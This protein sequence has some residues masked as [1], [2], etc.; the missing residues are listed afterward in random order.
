MAKYR[1]TKKYAEGSNVTRGRL[2]QL[3]RQETGPEKNFGNLVGDI[4]KFA[5]N[6]ALTPIETITGRN[7]YDPEFTYSTMNKVDAVSSGVSSAATDIAGTYFLGPFYTGGK[8]AIQAGVNKIDADGSWDNTNAQVAMFGGPIHYGHGSRVNNQ[9]IPRYFDASMVTSMMGSGGGGGFDMGSLMGMFGGQGGG[10]NMW[11]DLSSIGNNA[12]GGGNMNL[13][14]IMNTS[15]GGQNPGGGSSFLSAINPNLTGT[16]MTSSVDGIT[17]NEKG[18]I[19]LGATWNTRKMDLGVGQGEGFGADFKTTMSGMGNNMATNAGSMNLNQW[20][21]MLT[22]GDP[23]TIVNA[24]NDAGRNT[25]NWSGV[26]NFVNNLTSDTV[27][28]TKAKEI[29]AEAIANQQAI[30]TDQSNMNRYSSEGAADFG[31]VDQGNPMQDAYTKNAQGTSNVKSGWA[32]KTGQA[33]AQVGD[34]ASS[35]VSGDMSSMGGGMDMTSMM[36]MMGTARDGGNTQHPQDDPTFKMWYAKNARRPDVM[37][38]GNTDELKAIFLKEIGMPGNEMP[39]FSG[40]IDGYGNIDKSNRTPE[41]NS[42]IIGGMNKYGSKAKYNM[43][44]NV[45]QGAIPPGLKM[46]NG[47]LNVPENYQGYFNIPG[48]NHEDGGTLMNTPAEGQGNTLIEA[49]LNEGAEVKN[50]ETYIYSKTT[51][52][53][54]TGETFKK[55]KDKRE[56]ESLQID[57]LL[58][59]SEIQK[60][61]Y[62]LNALTRRK[63]TL[64]LEE[65]SDRALQ[66][67]IK[68]KNE[69]KDTLELEGLLAANTNISKKGTYRRGGRTR[70]L[71]E[72]QK[73]ML[74]DMLEK[75]MIETYQD[76]SN[77][78]KPSM[79]DY[80]WNNGRGGWKAGGEEKYN[81][82]LEAWKN[83]DKTTTEENDD[84]TRLPNEKEFDEINRRQKLGERTEDIVNDINNRNL[85]VSPDV[86]NPINIPVTNPQNQP[87]VNTDDDLPFSTEVDANGNTRYM[88]NGI[89]RSAEEYD[90]L[91]KQ[92]NDDPDNFATVPFAPGNIDVKTNTEVPIETNPLIPIDP[93]GRNINLNPNLPPNPETTPPPNNQTPNIPENNPLDITPGNPDDMVDDLLE[94]IDSKKVDNVPVVDPRDPSTDPLTK[95]ILDQSD[96]NPPVESTVPN[97]PRDPST[98]PLTKE[99]LDQSDVNQ[100]VESTVPNNPNPNAGEVAGPDE[101]LWSMLE[102][103]RDNPGGTITDNRT[104]ANTEGGGG[105]G[106]GDGGDGTTTPGGGTTTNEN[107]VETNQ[108]FPADHCPTGECPD[109]QG[110]CLPC[111]NENVVTANTTPPNNPPNTNPNTNPNITNNTTSNTSSYKFMQHNINPYDWLGM[112]GL[113]HGALSGAANTRENWENTPPNVNFMKDVYKKPIHRLNMNTEI[114]DAANMNTDRQLREDLNTQLQRIRTSGNSFQNV[115]ARSQNAYNTYASN[116]IDADV[117]Y[118]LMNLGLQKDIADLEGK[119]RKL[120]LEGEGERDLADR[121]D[122]DNYYTQRGKDIQNTA[123]NMM[124]MAKN[125]NAS[126]MEWL[127]ANAMNDL[128]GGNEPLDL[129]NTENTTNIT[130]ITNH[131]DGTTCPGG[132][133]THPDHITEDGDPNDNTDGNDNT[134][135]NTTPGANTNTFYNVSSGNNFETNFSGNYAPGTAGHFQEFARGMNLDLGDFGASGTEWE[136][137]DNNI[138]KYT[139]AAWD[140]SSNAYRD[141]LERSGQLGS[142]TGITEPSELGGTNLPFRRRLSPD[143]GQYSTYTNFG[144]FDNA[145]DYYNSLSAENQQILKENDPD[146]FGSFRRGSRVKYGYGSRARRRPRKYQDAHNVLSDKVVDNY[147]GLGITPDMLNQMNVTPSD[148]LLTSNLYPDDFNYTSGDLEGENWRPY[149]NPELS[150]ASSGVIMENLNMGNKTLTDTEHAGEISS[151]SDGTTFLQTR[152]VSRTDVDDDGTTRTTT[153]YSEEDF[154]KAD[155]FKNFYATNKHAE[156]SDYTKTHWSPYSFDYKTIMHNEGIVDDNWKKGEHKQ[157]LMKMKKEPTKFTHGG[158]VMSNVLRSRQRNQATSDQRM[159]DFRNFMKNRK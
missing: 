134:T 20:G 93:E 153:N 110:N 151:H 148:T 92:W 1:Y 140:V 11:G 26:G 38:A 21:S 78:K 154:E 147:G 136:G 49:E 126:A 16:P 39:L 137:V 80:K 23:N 10:S 79:K 19:D 98:D 81:A 113:T 54:D 33:I 111:E 159:N 143:A 40:E 27:Q 139:T 145:Q 131:S 64:L 61:E 17:Y 105:G 158:N 156:D 99:I 75:G 108:V 29:K 62:K 125:G 14:N 88:V 32:D 52:H 69:L 45:K 30:E 83:R 129:G 157:V 67:Q 63:T 34:F 58:A 36:N 101:D 109:A 138:G 149:Y 102:E 47:V 25:R 48:K 127:K 57:K 84:N 46:Q 132:N 144:K 18:N 118:G 68:Q 97:D 116:A 86:E 15:L 115:D 72:N 117:K 112:A 59:D 82:A 135:V 142:L 123:K 3:Q 114:I 90:K 41:L 28:E 2:D 119:D 155:L 150:A 106:E 107:N 24:S 9:G 95:E 141:Y 13:S 77:V 91:V 96:M 55:R 104:T 124:E 71:N 37:K 56:K 70:K 121:E 89:E 22:E 31:V 43:G 50:G 128:G 42:R 4:G 44:S 85:N 74:G 130:N 51:K 146:V 152:P 94:S 6:Q 53:P 65:E 8:K 103:Q 5:I 66:D 35:F 120:F 100:P 76:A 122:M 7:F 133:C 73:T 60:D 12:G 87:V